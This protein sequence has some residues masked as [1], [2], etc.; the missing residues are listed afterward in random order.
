MPDYRM[1]FIDHDGRTA[2]AKDLHC[3]N[4][5]QAV[6]EARQAVDGR[7]VELWQADRMVVRLNAK[8]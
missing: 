3:E 7:D 5:V 6:E 8:R 4:D 2:S 1:Y